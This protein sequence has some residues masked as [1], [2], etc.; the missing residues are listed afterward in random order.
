MLFYRSEEPQISLNSPGIVITNIRLDHF[1][2]LLFA[3]KPSAIVALS[4][5]NA[6]EALHRSVVDAAAYT[7]HAL[8]HASTFQLVVK[9][10]TCILKASV[11]M[12]QGMRVWIGLYRLVQCFKH[13]RVVIV[14]P[15]NI[16]DDAPVI[17]VQNS[18]E[19]QL[20]YFYPV[21]PSELCHI[22]EPFFV[23]LVCPKLAVKNISG[24]ILRTL[25]LPGAA[26][27]G[28]FYCGTDIFYP[29]Y[30]EDPFL[31][32]PNTVVV[33][34]IIPET[35]V[36]FV[37]TALMNLLNNFCQFLV[38]DRPFAAFAGSPSVISG[39]RDM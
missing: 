14:L 26:G 16:R 2:E 12:E 23:W 31:I 24:Q 19:V 22:R 1:N 21:I 34:Q 29:A 5:Q 13:K 33:D 25:F 36:A 35:A 4:F 38:P 17:Q 20:V 11:R 3:C 8:G 9:Y 30:T 27:T 39:S 32:D 37:W 18:T 7:R 10:F 28:I 15:E 6:P